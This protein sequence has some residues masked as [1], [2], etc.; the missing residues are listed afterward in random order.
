MAFW[1]ELW[2][3][4]ILR[5]VATLLTPAIIA[6][7]YYSSRRLVR[8]FRALR[9]VE[10]ALQA[11]ARTRD[12][13]GTWVEGPGFWL[14]QPIVP[15]WKDY[16]RRMLASIPI[17][18]VATAKGGVGKT[19]MSASLAAHFAMKW[20]QKREDPQTP[21]PL[22][23]LLIDS[24]FQASMTT[25]T[26]PDA[27]RFLVPS[28][29]NKLVSGEIGDGLDRGSTPRVSRP[30]MVAL[31][32][33]TVQAA[34]DL[35]QAENRVMV[36]WLLPL[37][38]VDL[39]AWLL[40]LFKLRAPQSPRSVKDVRYLLAEALHGSKVQQDYDLIIIDSPPRL[41]TSHVQALC[42]STHVLVPTIL[43][44]LSG[45]AVARYVDQV[46]THTL[47]PQGDKARAIC[48]HLNLLGVVCDMVP[49]MPNWDLT[50]PVN[51]LRQSLVGSRLPVHIFPEDCFIRQRPPYR[52]CAGERIA[53][54]AVGQAQP[55]QQLR[56]EVDRLGDQIAS[57]IGAT[58]KGWVR[59]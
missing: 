5:I 35:A 47:G 20:K 7:V 55:Y 40:R 27:E 30:E 33:W 54:A 12:E 31:S 10:E 29:A 56:E 18:M 41:T 37:S 38:D 26:V 3:S 39:L 14:K 45:D 49:N 2:D 11:V 46:A 44:R 58:G 59:T 4:V 1:N 19:T 24:D 36:E 32:A 21:K 22:R 42:A 23:V 48:P 28:K 15:P 53:Y 25:M 52:D 9:L 16:G 57:M 17:L 34:Y 6:A 51:V 8:A 50:G 43:D 13:N